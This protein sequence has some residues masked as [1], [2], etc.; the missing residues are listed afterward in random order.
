MST[1]V[2]NRLSEHYRGDMEIYAEF[3]GGYEEQCKVCGQRYIQFY[4]WKPD[5]NYFADEVKRKE[6][7]CREKFKTN[8]SKRSIWMA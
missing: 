5:G 6:D 1:C 8:W 4:S 3:D 2:H 7:E